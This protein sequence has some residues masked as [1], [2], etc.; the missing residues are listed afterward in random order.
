MDLQLNMRRVRYALIA[1]AAF[2]A[3]LVLAGAINSASAEGVPARGKVKAADV[4]TAARLTWTGIYGGGF[5]GFGMGEISPSGSPTGISSRGPL[6]GAAAGFTI[7]TGQVVFGGE[8]SYAW[9]FGDL[10]DLGVKTE[11][12]Y[13]GRVGLAHG[14]ALPYIHG[15]FAQLSVDGLGQIDGWKYGIGVELR[16][17]G[18]WSLDV[19]GG[20]SDYDISSIAPGIDANMLWGRVGLNKRFDMPVGLF[21][22]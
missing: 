2:I 6:A 18:G 14:N 13:T 7:Q 11:I 10:K 4:T 22:Q 9:F 15:S 17:D 3:T 21:G 5:G 12:E 20:K 19:R 16:L 1:F 8:I